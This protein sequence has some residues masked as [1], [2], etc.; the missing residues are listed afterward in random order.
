[1]HRMLTY[2][3]KDARTWVPICRNIHTRTRVLT[4]LHTH[5][6]EAHVHSHSRSQAHTS[7][8][9]RSPVQ[10]L[11]TAG[12]GQGPSVREG[13]ALWGKAAARQAAAGEE[14][15][16]AGGSPPAQ[17]TDSSGLTLSLGTR[18][19][20]CLGSIIIAA[21]PFNLFDLDDSNL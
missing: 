18:S 4:P 11:S 13:T 17:E 5:A 9:F 21:P 6:R 16:W 2:S 1:M 7:T 20:C 10:E 15:G 19:G 14:P 12:W 3:H 8:P